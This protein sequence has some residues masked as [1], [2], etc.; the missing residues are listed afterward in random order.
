[1]SLRAAAR[2]LVYQALD[3]VLADGNVSAASRG[4]MHNA[5]DTMRGASV[6]ADELRCAE[7]ISIE[8]HRLSWALCRSDQPSIMSARDALKRL[9]NGWMDTRITNA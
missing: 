8:M 2:V 7:N 9:A 4:A 5:V 1:M 6:P 3:Q